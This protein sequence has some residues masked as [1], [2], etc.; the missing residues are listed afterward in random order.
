MPCM[1]L[2]LLALHVS[3]SAPFRLVWDYIPSNPS[4][5]TAMDASHTQCRSDLNAARGE[6]EEEEGEGEGGGDMLYTDLFNGEEN[7]ESRAR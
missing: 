1:Y 6:E 4:P 7:K 5:M 3:T 2:S